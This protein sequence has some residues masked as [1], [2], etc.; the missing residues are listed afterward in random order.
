MRQVSCDLAFSC[1]ASY[2]ALSCFIIFYRFPEVRSVGDVKIA[3]NDQP[4]K[5]PQATK[6]LY[7]LGHPQTK[8]CP[9]SKN[10]E[11]G[12]PRGFKSQTNWKDLTKRLNMLKTWRVTD[13]HTRLRCVD[14]AAGV[15][16]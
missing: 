5:C 7:Q 4:G 6:T 15:H 16:S 9:R 12:G 3:E 13:R 14:L 10:S 2:V 11:R 1:L 8:L